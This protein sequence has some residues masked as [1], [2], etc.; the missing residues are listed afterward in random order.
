MHLPSQMTPQAGH[1]LDPT[2]AKHL[3]HRPHAQ[4]VSPHSGRHLARQLLA[5]LFPNGEDILHEGVHRLWIV[6]VQSGILHDLWDVLGLLHLLQ[7]EALTQRLIIPRQS[8]CAEV[9]PLTSTQHLSLIHISEPTRLRRISYAVFCLKKKK[10]KK[11]KT[12]TIV[13]HKN[14]KKKQTTNNK[15]K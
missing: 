11:K 2:H 6:S 1:G 13:Q 12:V 14:K 7:N 9:L 8:G 10:K 5:R 3:H 15:K 4:E